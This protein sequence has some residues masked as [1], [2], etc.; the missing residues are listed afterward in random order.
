MRFRDVN[1]HPEH[2]GS[3]L[4]SFLVVLKITKLGM[5]LVAL[6]HLLHVASKSEK[7]RHVS[8]AHPTSDDFLFRLARA[9]SFRLFIGVVLHRMP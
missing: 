7:T 9:F 8:D 6:G 1:K 3:T 4:I 2:A 5:I